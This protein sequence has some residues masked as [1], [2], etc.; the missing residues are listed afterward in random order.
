M[1]RASKDR[2][3]LVGV[4]AAACVACC[5]A[6]VLAFLGGLSIAGIAGVWLIGGAGLVI[7]AVAAGTYV[8]LGRRGRAH[9]CTVA[10]TETCTP[11]ADPLVTVPIT[12]EADR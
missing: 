7:A 12:T 8:V 9:A 3:S 6:P 10:C 2:L 4:G 11:D 1:N 5:A